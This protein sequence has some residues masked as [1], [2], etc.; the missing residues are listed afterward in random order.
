MK[1]KLKKLGEQGLVACWEDSGKIALVGT[2]NV[3][4]QVGKDG[5]LRRGRKDG[6]N[7]GDMAETAS[8]ERQRGENSMVDA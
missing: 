8:G 4:W 5:I 1:N 7:M 3:I 6:M 2:N